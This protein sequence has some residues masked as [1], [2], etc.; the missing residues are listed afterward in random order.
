MAVF[1]T[2]CT[3]VVVLASLSI[4]KIG[5]SDLALNSVLREEELKFVQYLHSVQGKSRSVL[6]ETLAQSEEMH[7]NEGIVVLYDL[8][9]FL[10]DK[11][12]KYLEIGSNDALSASLILRHPYRT[13]VQAV[14]PCELDNTLVGNHSQKE[15]IR[16]TYHR[17]SPPQGC[18]WHSPWDLRVGHSPRELPQFETFDIIFISGDHSASGVLKDYRA[19]EKLLRPGGFMVFDEYLNFELFPEVKNA[20]DDIASFTHLRSIG[21]LNQTKG[22]LGFAEK[23]VGQFIF[24]KSGTFTTSLSTYVAPDVQ[25]ML[26]IVTC[27]HQR[28]DGSTPDNLERMFR[29]IQKQSYKSWK[30]FLTGDGYD[31][32]EWNSISFKSDPRVDMFNLEE[33]GE[34]GKLSEELL[35]ITAGT[36][37]VNMGIDRALA[38]GHEW[39]VRL[40]DDDI[41][42]D[43]HLQNIVRGIQSKATFVMTSAQHLGGFLPPLRATTQLDLSHIPPEP[44]QVIQSSVA[45]NAKAL[46][47]RYTISGMP[48]DACMWARIIFDAHFY[49][50]YVPIDSV[51]HLS[52]RSSQGEVYVGRKWALNES[53][54][55]H[56][57]IS[58]NDERYEVMEYTSIVTDFFPLQVSKYCGHVIGPTM[59][60]PKFK[61]VHEEEIP[62]Y[63]RVVPELKDMNVWT[64]V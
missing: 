42:D 37:A 13:S 7:C 49:P 30:L 58:K 20:V 51:H 60:S 62:Y 34:R 1:A 35:W 25:P 10:G 11:L 38:A 24:Q 41:W 27:T 55:P 57:W 5:M 43:D 16:A 52:E 18:S 26:C 32:T 22:T 4:H 40:D 53:D 14:H 9:S 23:H 59:D 33:P 31:M 47:S 56:G 50:T 8:R 46:T 12:G 19:T 6:L 36:K 63:I 48:G 54:G 21:I 28:P 39:I 45:F 44:C 64:L 3:L 17:N 15:G 61:K 2:V 29:Q